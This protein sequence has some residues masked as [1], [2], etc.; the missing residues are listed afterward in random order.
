MRNT[1]VSILFILFIISVSAFAQTEIY[2]SSTGQDSNDG[3]SAQTPIKSFSKVLEKISPG[4]TVYVMPGKYTSGLSLKTEHS[5]T[6]DKYITFKAYNPDDKPLFYYG[7]NNK[8]NCIDIQASYIIIDGLE[9]EGYNQSF[10]QT[11]AKSDSLAA[12]NYSKKYRELGGSG[13]D[14]S[15]C[16]KYNT[17]AISI[18]KGGKGGGFPHHVTIRNCKV[19]DFPGGG[20]GSQQS[21]WITIE[22]NEVYNC[23]WYC[24]YACSGISVLNPYNSDNMDSEYKIHVE[25]NTVYNNHT[26][27]PWCTSS[28]FRRSDGN[29]I[30]IDVNVSPDNSTI[31]EIK[32]EGAYRGKTLVANN[33][34]YFNGGSG[35]HAF[36]AANV[37]IINNTA[38]FNE[39]RYDGEYGEIF[40][41]LG[42]NNRIVNNIMYA[43][44]NH[45]CNN[46]VR[47]GGGTY[48]HNLYFGGRY[49]LSATDSYGDP[50]FVRVPLHVGDDVDFHLSPTSMAIG[51]GISTEYMPLADKDG[52]VRLEKID[53]GAY[54]GNSP[55]VLSTIQK[56][57]DIGICYDLLGKR[58]S[59]FLPGILIVNGK[60]VLINNTQT[61]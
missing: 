25:G 37:D 10:D 50:G 18:G 31:P 45:S 13:F 44:P 21:D 55:E 36:K 56:D 19:H 32:A 46:Y 8:W 41:Q 39:Q 14:W 49:I 38:C 6:K 43:S 47:E 26:K 40:S 58:I 27:I 7:G 59:S 16:A 3:L 51:A 52:I 2:V 15:G 17:N 5:G 1:R 23:A 34:S 53:V 30:I 24:M 12:Y 60:K 54:C 28:N 4:S 33:V 9:F 48:D 22:N 61:K 42:R 57:E 20:I 35:I 11:S 29:G